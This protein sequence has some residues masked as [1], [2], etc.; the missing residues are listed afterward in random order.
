M[1]VDQARAAI[2]HNDLEYIRAAVDKVVQSL[3]HVIARNR[4]VGQRSK[5]PSNHARDFEQK[6]FHIGEVPENTA[7]TN[8]GPPCNRF[9]RGLIFTGQDKFHPGG[10]DPAAA[11]F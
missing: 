4:A 9:G 8:A 7:Q 2:G 10:N 5:M 3:A 1:P 11:F 6:A